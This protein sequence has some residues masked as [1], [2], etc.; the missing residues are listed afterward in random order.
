[1]HGPDAVGVLHNNGGDHDE[2][3]DAVIDQGRGVRDDASPPERISAAN[4]ESTGV[5]RSAGHSRP[6]DAQKVNISS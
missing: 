4:D 3:Y 5:G 1:M 2:R 6:R